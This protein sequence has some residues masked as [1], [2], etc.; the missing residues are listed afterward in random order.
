MSETA[1]APRALLIIKHVS[2]EGTLNGSLILQQ[3]A[4]EAD[5]LLGQRCRQ[6]AHQHEIVTHLESAGRCSKDARQ[7]LRELEA[8]LALQVSDRDRLNRQLGL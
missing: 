5:R 2:T 8:C 4:A 6:V 7:L 3:Y 1:S